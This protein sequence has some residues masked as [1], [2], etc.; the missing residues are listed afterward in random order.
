MRKLPYCLVL[1]LVAVSLGNPQ[2]SVHIHNGFLTGQEY[3]DFDARTQQGYAMG[4]VDGMLLAPMFGAP[5]DAA[6]LK[7]LANCI[8]GMSNAQVKAIIDKFLKDHPERWNDPMHA[9]TYTAM[10]EACSRK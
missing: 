6:K 4:V 10:M 1:F 2:S 3:L 5:S 7:S 9:V 8:E